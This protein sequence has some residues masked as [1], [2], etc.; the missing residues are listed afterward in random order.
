[1]YI[2]IPTYDYATGEWGH[3]EFVTRETFR[4]FLWSIFK[5]PGE[6]HFDECSLLFNKQARKFNQ[7]KFYCPAPPKSKDFVVYWDTEKEKCRNGVIFKNGKH[8]WYLTRDY[9]MWLNFLPIYNKE[10]SKFTGR[11]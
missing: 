3:T 6:Y 2:K 1:M 4:E 8:T 5:K 9:Y 7:D 11:A 10:V